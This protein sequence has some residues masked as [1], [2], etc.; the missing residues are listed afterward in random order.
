MPKSG[1]YL[2][3]LN[4]RDQDR[5]LQSRDRDVGKF[6]RDETLGRSRDRLETET[7]RPRPHPCHGSRSPTPSGQNPIWPDSR[8]K[9]TSE[10]ESW[11]DSDSE[12]ELERIYFRS[13]NDML[14]SYRNRVVTFAIVVQTRHHSRWWCIWTIWRGEPNLQFLPTTLHSLPLALF[15]GLPIYFMLVTFPSSYAYGEAGE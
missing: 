5:D 14:K 15:T 3:D 13:G 7:S 1:P 12:P 2:R 11:S 9:M 6:V 8:S 10:Q 4:S